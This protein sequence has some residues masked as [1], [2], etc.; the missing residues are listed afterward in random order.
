[1]IKTVI[2]KLLPSHLRELLI[3]YGIRNFLEYYYY[4]NFVKRYFVFNTNKLKYFF[5]LYNTTWKNERAMEISIALYYLHLYNPEEIIE[6]GNVLSYYTNVEH[7]VVDKHEQGKNVCTIDIVNFNSDK[8]Y[9]LL[10]SISTLEHIGFDEEEKSPIKTKH[11]FVKFT[12]LVDNGG[13]I[14]VTFPVGYNQYLDNLV[15]NKEISFT[16]VYCFKRISKV[17]WLLCNWDEVWQQKYDFPFPAAN[18]LIV[19]IKKL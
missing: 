4:K 19:G 1:M 15:K 14:L 8:K 16:N 5:H 9:K 18:G 10:I 11:A 13:I 7:I 17:K 12:E 2:N 6:V 3:S